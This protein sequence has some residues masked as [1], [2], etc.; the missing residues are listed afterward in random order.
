[1]FSCRFITLKKIVAQVFRRRYTIC[2]NKCLKV[3]QPLRK[4]SYSKN[5]KNSKAITIFILHESVVLKVKKTQI[6]STK[7]GVYSSSVNYCKYL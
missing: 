1:M 5:K 6:K 2:N 7:I 3:W 4:G